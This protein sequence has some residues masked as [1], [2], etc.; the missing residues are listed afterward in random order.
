MREFRGDGHV[1]ALVDA[2]LDGCEALVTHGA[3][4]EVPAPVLQ[5]TRGR[6]DEDWNAAVESLRSRGWLDDRGAFT[7]IGRTARQAIEDTTDR[8]AIEPYAAIG[9]AGCAELRRLVRPW[10]A[11]LSAVFPA[12]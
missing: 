4:G 11:A 1:A 8:L 12:R 10:S 2:D 9:E 5:A 7:E 6:S 3:A